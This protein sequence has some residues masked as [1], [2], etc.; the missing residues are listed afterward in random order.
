[1]QNS[2]LALSQGF[3]M[4]SYGAP[5][6]P[7]SGMTS[8][9]SAPPPPPSGMTSFFSAPIPPPCGMMSFGGPPPPPMPACYSSAP[10]P[11]LA[12]RGPPS[13]SS[14][15]LISGLT[16]DSFSLFTPQKVTDGLSRLITLQSAE[17]CWSLNDSL[18][19]IMGRSL[20]VLKS[21][22]PNGV[23]EV[24]WGTVLALVLLETKYS[25]QRDEWELISMKS[26]MWIQGQVLP[27][28]I[29]VTSLTEQAK[30]CLA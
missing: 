3:D 2:L 29:T 22:C 12:S 21:S 14:D 1:M 23:S 27:S 17:G 18:A 19:S 16:T 28:G 11:P 30:K 8:F 25:S 9:F 15:S 7:P 24:V 6:P 5:P 10:A 26:E 20:S 4:M 13:A